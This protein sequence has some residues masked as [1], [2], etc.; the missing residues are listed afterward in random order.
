M[1]DVHD[2]H[3]PIVTWP[4]PTAVD[5]VQE[6]IVKHQSFTSLPGS[7]LV[8]YTETVGRVTNQA[9]K[10]KTALFKLQTHI[11][12]LTPRKKHF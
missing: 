6:G 11:A 3:C 2:Q 4:I 7:S 10:V 1:P 9:C 8:G 12:N 5:R